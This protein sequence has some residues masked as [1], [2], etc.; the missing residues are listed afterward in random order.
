MRLL[1]SL[2]I[3]T[4]IL[5]RLQI[6]LLLRNRFIFVDTHYGDT[7]NLTSNLHQ[8]FRPSKGWKLLWYFRDSVC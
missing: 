8:N 7:K 1:I 2:A 6:S 3:F 4:T 5:K